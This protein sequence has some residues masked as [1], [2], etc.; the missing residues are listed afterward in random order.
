[1]GS[2][3]VAGEDFSGK[4]APSPCVGM[5]CYRE[6]RL[7][8]RV[9]CESQGKT[10][11]RKGGTAP[12]SNTGTS[13]LC[14]KWDPGTVSSVGGAGRGRDPSDSGTMWHSDSPPR[15][16]WTMSPLQT[17]GGRVSRI[18]GHLVYIPE[19]RGVCGPEGGPSRQ[20]KES[21]RGGCPFEP[22]TASRLFSWAL[23]CPVP[24]CAHDGAAS[25]CLFLSLSSFSWRMAV[26]ST[27]RST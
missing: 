3:C 10:R 1:M 23:E 11:P 8:C 6:E 5:Q 14:S 16:R 7:V 25:S 21:Q 26:T 4:V 27:P 15:D 20:K 13:S 22:G 12:S 2:V 24:L 18:R 9:S 17:G 19:G